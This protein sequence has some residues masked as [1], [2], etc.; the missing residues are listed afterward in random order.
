MIFSR[1][2]VLQLLALSCV[3]S[4]A[5]GRL[6]KASKEEQPNK[7]RSLFNFFDYLPDFDLPDGGDVIDSIQDTLCDVGVGAV[8]DETVTGNGPRCKPVDPLSSQDF[9]V[10][11]YI[12][13]TWYVQK[14]QEWPLL[15]KKQMNCVLHT[16][17]WRDS[18]VAPT[19]GNTDAYLSM[20]QYANDK[21]PGGTVLSLEMYTAWAGVCLKQ[22][23]AG[24]FDIA[25]CG[26]ADVGGVD[27]GAV[28]GI[29]DAFIDATS[30]PYWVLAVGENYE[31]AIVSGGQPDVIRKTEKV[32]LANGNK[33]E[34]TYCAPPKGDN[35]L[36]IYNGAGLF[37]MTRGSAVPDGA[38]DEMM[39]KLEEMQIW[40]GDLIDVKHDGCGDYNGA[41]I[42]ESSPDNGITPTSRGNP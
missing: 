27:M 42:I 18:M 30:G 3:F 12:N 39:A 34:V 13:G 36:D 16:Y 10:E 2:S 28:S 8:C 21:K 6:R 40:S 33:Q 17:M 19:S 35:L 22:E 37:L 9:D 38:M 11:Q 24:N 14:Q 4:F 7:R 31:W 32:K 25:N 1:G 26:V 29:L 41:T 5:S 15:G 20:Y 23:S